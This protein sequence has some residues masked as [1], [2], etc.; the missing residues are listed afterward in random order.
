[1]STAASLKCRGRQLENSDPVEMHSL[2]HAGLSRR[3]EI[4]I[5]RCNLP[6]GAEIA[7]TLT[8]RFRLRPSD[9]NGVGWLQMNCAF[10]QCSTTTPL[11]NRNH[12]VNAMNKSPRRAGVETVAV[13]LML[14]TVL[15]VFLT[16]GACFVLAETTKHSV[17]LS[18]LQRLHYLAG[19]AISP[20]GKQIA[21]SI[22]EELYLVSLGSS[23]PPRLLAGGVA[24]A[25][26]PDSRRLAYYAE[27]KGLFRLCLMDV[28]QQRGAISEKMTPE[29][30]A[31]TA[32]VCP[33]TATK[34]Y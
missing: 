13:G 11:A 24:P 12:K 8:T 1:L 18:D 5:S 2:L 10:R 31:A 19:R 30:N 7:F 25:W 17:T 21:Y 27:Q 3:T 15:A 23:S 20:N 29:P 33:L 6:N 9:Y 26:S 16:A 32:P 34:S 14:C 22:G 28:S 4:A